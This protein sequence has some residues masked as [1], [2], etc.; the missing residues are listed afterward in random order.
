[1]RWDAPAPREREAGER[2]W[3]VVR[4]A[5][6]ARTPHPRVHQRRGALVAIAIAFAIAAAA[7]SPPGLAV[8]GSIRDAVRGSTSRDELTSL[9]APGPLLVQTSAGAWVVQQDGSK[10]FLAGYNDAVWSPHGLFV[11]AARSNELVAMEPNGRIHWTLARSRPIGS[12]EWSYEG[13]RIAYLSGASLR[14]VNGDGTGDRLITP[15]VNV[16]PAPSLAWRPGTHV[17]AY[18]NSRSQLTLLDVDRNRIL[19]RRPL[20]G[21]EHLLWSDDGRRLLAVAAHVELFDPRGDLVATIHQRGTVVGV[22]FLPHRE[23]FTLATVGR[24]RSA[25]TLYGRRT[26]LLFSGAGEVGGIAWSPDARW[27]LVDWRGAN[28]WL[29]MRTVG[30][31]RVRPVSNID[32]IFGAGPEAPLRVVGWCCP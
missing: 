14:V 1:M 17:L 3:E 7:L 30:A 31:P 19:W 23:A 18:T 15:S 5:W 4:S 6:E 29:F 28:Q 21:A 9:P 27:L 22:A 20:P 32:N 24:G 2:S 26:K 13:F 16:T 25:V 10:R 8:L 12:P 11:A